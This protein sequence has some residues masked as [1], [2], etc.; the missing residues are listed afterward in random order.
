MDK[1]LGLEAD[2][3]TPGVAQVHITQIL[4]IPQKNV[5]NVIWWE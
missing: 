1:M 2:A 4:F 5:L 3:E